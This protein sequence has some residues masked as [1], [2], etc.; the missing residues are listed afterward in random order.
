MSPEFSSGLD[1][2]KRE[3]EELTRK[4]SNSP[5]AWHAALARVCG[6]LSLRI[7]RGGA[8]RAE[9]EGWAYTLEETAKLMRKF[10]GDA[11]VKK[12]SRQAGG[13]RRRAEGGD[14]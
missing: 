4:L 6:R 13:R 8:S 3:M 11:D 5:A 9:L 10:I 7:T 1:D 2:P 12:R 14:A